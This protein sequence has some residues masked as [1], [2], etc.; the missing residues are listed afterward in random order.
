MFVDTVYANYVHYNGTTCFLA[1]IFYTLQ[2]YCDFAGYSLMAIGIAAALG[3]NLINNFRRPYLAVSVTDF[4]KRWH[5]SLTRWLTQQVY[6]PLGGSR[7][8]KAKNY[9][10]IMITFL[11]SGIW[12]GANWTFIFWGMIH[13][14]LQIIEKSFG[15]QKYAGHNAALK[16]GRISLTFLLV[17]FAWVFFRMPTLGDGFDIIGRMFTSV[18]TVQFTGVF[19]TGLFPLAIIFVGLAFLC[20]KDLRDEF[21]AAKFLF[22]QRP[23]FRWGVYIV[24]FVLII[25]SGVLDGSQFIY[26]NF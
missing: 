23:V 9:L 22:L 20:F 15:W 11:V 4:W 24:L 17:N 25:T 8:S 14:L 3:F 7:C 13:G 21:C 10:N 16:M 1:S 2:I 19:T 12:H 18:G 5:I 6:I 26:V